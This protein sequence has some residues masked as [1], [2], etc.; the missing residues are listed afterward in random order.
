MTYFKRKTHQKRNLIAT[1]KDAIFCEYCSHTIQSA[2][3]NNI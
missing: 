2:T 1:E 3:K